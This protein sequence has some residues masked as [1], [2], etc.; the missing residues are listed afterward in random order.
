VPY[1]CFGFEGVN[2]DFIR[3]P[4]FFNTDS[5]GLW[6]FDTGAFDVGIAVS[7]GARR[8]RRALR[9]EVSLEV[10]GVFA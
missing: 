4:T 10:T 6:A 3:D 2:Q 5:L 7:I 1:Y 9:A 8:G